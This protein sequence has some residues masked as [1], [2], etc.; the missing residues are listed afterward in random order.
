MFVRGGPWPCR[1]QIK[2]SQGA[3][4]PSFRRSRGRLSTLTPRLATKQQGGREFCGAI[5]QQLSGAARTGGRSPREVLSWRKR[6]SDIG[7]RTER[8]MAWLA[9]GAAH[10]PAH[11]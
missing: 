10:Q 8:C 11:P 2:V 1:L 3:P 7:C 5:W 9:S 4:Q 6:A